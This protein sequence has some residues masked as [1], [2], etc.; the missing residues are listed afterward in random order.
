[1]E[2][3]LKLHWSPRS[4]FV[5]KVMI[6]VHEKGLV[7]RV[8]VVRTRVSVK[9]PNTELLSDNPLGQIPTLILDDG[10]AIYDSPV[11]SEYL[12]CIGDGPSLLPTSG[13]E[14]FR[15]LT[16]QA[17][18]DG[19]LDTVL[20]WREWPQER[21]LAEHDPSYIAAFGL[22]VKTSLDRLEEIVGHLNAAPFNIGHIAIGTLLSYLDFRWQVLEWRNGRPALT[23]WHESFAARPSVVATHIVDDSAATNQQPV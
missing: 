19:I 1:M 11:I 21:D 14:R 6:V 17:L 5:R 8:D 23:A 20:V 18:A 4:P 13:P 22:K 16:W 9:A 2:I 10:S 12:D 3:A 7:D 15:A